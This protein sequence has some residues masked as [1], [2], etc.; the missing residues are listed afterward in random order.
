MFYVTKN[1]FR[2][3]GQNDKKYSALWGTHCK[4]VML[5]RFPHWIILK[6]ASPR[7]IF[8]QEMRA[9]ASIFLNLVLYNL[10]LLNRSSAP[11]TAICQ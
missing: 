6:L 3:L 11:L 7:V 2:G 8:T 4:N 10:S 9:P 1:R 5:V